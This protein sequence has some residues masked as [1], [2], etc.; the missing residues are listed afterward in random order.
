MSCSPVSSYWREAK[1]VRLTHRKSLLVSTE[2]S[3]IYFVFILCHVKGHDRLATMGNRGLPKRASGQWDGLPAEEISPLRPEAPPVP[4]NHDTPGG[5][6]EATVSVSHACC[7]TS[8]HSWCL[9]TTQTS[10]LTVVE[11]K[12]LT[13]KSEKGGHG[14]ESKFQQGHIPSGN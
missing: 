5:Q 10:Y 7:N 11:V 1:H 4:V 8:P 13:Q 3:C 2:K 14:L 6:W 12:S 9:E